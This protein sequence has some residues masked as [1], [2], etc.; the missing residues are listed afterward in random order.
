MQ[1]EFAWDGQGWSFCHAERKVTAMDEILP[2]A[3]LL[4]GLAVGAGACW[5]VFHSKLKHAA[6]AAR[7]EIQAE[8]AALAARLAASDTTIESLQG[9]VAAGQTCLQERQQENT[10]LNS[11]VT[12]LETQLEQEQK[13][14]K[15]KLDMLNQAQQKLSDAFKALSSDALQNNNR[16]FLALAKSTLEK[17]QV[18]A[19]GDL[20]KRQQAIDALVKPV[21][22]SLKQVDAKLQD[23]EKQRLTAYA[24]LAEQVKLLNDN[25]IALRKETSNL[26]NALRRPEARGRWGEIQLRRVVEMAGMQEHCDFIE[27]QSVQTDEGRR[28]PDLTVQLPGGKNIVVDSKVPLTAFLESIEAA[29]E[30]TKLAKA[31]DHARYVR[32]HIDDL[33]KKAYFAQFEQAPEFVV[34]FLPAESFFSVALEHDP[35][36]IETGV[37]QNVIIATPTTLISLLKAVAYGWT[38]ERLA[39]NAR[40]ISQ[41]GK[42]L[43]TRLSIMGGHLTG[44]GKGLANA[45]EA[46]NKT[47]KSLETRVLVTARKFEDLH[48]TVPGKDLDSPALVEQTPRAPQKKELFTSERDEL[49]E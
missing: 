49:I 15:E 28:R 19:K 9:E 24:G 45:T 1:T 42:D 26:V 40:Q 6:T 8:N 44:L 31:K 3:M 33:S 32:K 29:D 16:S 17:Y 5:L 13:Q 21:G 35:R 34:L 38:Q 20:E 48:V 46:Y 41:L 47:V 23:I 37:E 25:Q 27:Q 12:Q 4:I 14:A 30:E 43:Y 22:E 10:S 18:T 2:I 36:L 39:E 11:R 7:S